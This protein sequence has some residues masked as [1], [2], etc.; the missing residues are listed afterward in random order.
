MQNAYAY[1]TQAII[2]KQIVGQISV[3]IIVNECKLYKSQYNKIKQIS[4]VD[5]TNVLISVKTAVV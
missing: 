4:W 5:Q 2:V 1:Y 3:L